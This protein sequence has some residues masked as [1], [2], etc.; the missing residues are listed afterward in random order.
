ME[1]D[2]DVF[3][4]PEPDRESKPK[5]QWGFSELMFKLLVASVILG[6]SI[7]LL[8]GSFQVGMELP[9]LIFLR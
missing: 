7:G 5:E 6:L 2:P 1:T 3:P 9:K 8:V 4:V